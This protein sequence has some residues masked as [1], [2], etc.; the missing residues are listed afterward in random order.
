MFNFTFTLV[1]VIGLSY[2]DLVARRFTLARVLD[3]SDLIH[4]CFCLQ[5]PNAKGT[6]ITS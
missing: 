5:I 6:F 4:R 2:A 1:V 3:S